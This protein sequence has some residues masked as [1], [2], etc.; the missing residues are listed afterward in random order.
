MLFCSRCVNCY[1]LLKVL[2]RQVLDLDFH[3]HAAGQLEFHQ[4]VHSLGGGVQDVDQA[5][6]RRQLELPSGVEVE[7][8][9]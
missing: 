4:S 2:A 9:V 5:L 1:F 8:K 6:E 7:I 3:F